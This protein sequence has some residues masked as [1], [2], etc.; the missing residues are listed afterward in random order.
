MPF[1]DK[2]SNKMFFNIYLKKKINYYKYI[3][4]ILTSSLAAGCFKT[5][6]QP[7]NNMIYEKIFTN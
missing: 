6:L 3:T 1:Y 7:W 2:L 4:G 5:F